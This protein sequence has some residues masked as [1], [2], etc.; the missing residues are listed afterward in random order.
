[1]VEEREAARAPH[2]AAGRLGDAIVQLAGTPDDSPDVRALLTE[3][4]SHAQAAIPRA[5]FVS[6]TAWEQGAPATVAMSSEVALAVDQVQYEDS[7]GPCLAALTEGR[8]VDV[9]EIATIVEWPGF[10]EAATSLG[11]R[12]SLSIALFAASGA[13]VA[14]LNIYS[15]EVGALV[16]LGRRIAGVFGPTVVGGPAL[17][18]GSEHLVRGITDAMAVRD[19]IQRALGTLMARRA[20]SPE[21]AYATLR[22]AAAEA[23][24]PVIDA[25]RELV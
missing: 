11:L 22:I 6:V 8:V 7:D 18:P 17:D 19:T 2:V 21:E 4:V 16:P 20:I 25:A 23:S 15:R 3:I 13:A 10:R 14:A 9:P 5:S 24:V 12:S 1:M